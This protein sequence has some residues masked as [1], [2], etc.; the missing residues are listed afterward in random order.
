[1]VAEHHPALEE[2]EAVVLLQLVHG[3][4]VPGKEQ[5]LGS[6]GRKCALVR[7]VVDGEHG[8]AAPCRSGSAGISRAQVN[9]NQRRLPIVDVKNVG[10][11]ELF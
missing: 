9:R 6:L 11:A 7:G 5:F 3:E 8:A 10:H 1:M 2:V 4:D